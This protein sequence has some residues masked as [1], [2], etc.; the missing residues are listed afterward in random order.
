MP[1]MNLITS[2]SLKEMVT[3]LEVMDVTGDGKDNIVL[4][5]VSGSLRVYDY[6]GGNNVVKELF[7]MT[8]LVPI[9]S[10]GI[11][12]VTGNGTPDFVVGGL[13]NTL[14]VVSIGKKSLEVKSNAMLGNLPIS[15][16]VANVLNDG[17]EE[18]VV[19]TNDNALRC[20]GWYDT[21]L[22]K[23]AH[24]VVKRPVFSMKPLRS[25]GTSYTRFVFGDDSETLYIYQYADDRLHEIANAKVSGEV[26]LVATGRVTGRRSDDVVIASSEKTITLFE[27]EQKSVSTRARI[28][29]PGSISSMKVGEM[30]IDGA[31]SQGQVLV[32]LANSK[33]S[34]LSVEGREFFEDASIKTASKSADSLVA[35]GDLSGDGNKEIVQAVGN[36]LF[37][38]AI[39]SE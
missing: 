15:L 5:T 9:S 13:D 34:M 2:H 35:Y 39:E 25:E 10:F 22:D 33:L 28:R 6:V 30:L 14:R 12:D 11:G 7:R 8:D 20:Y 23:L 21:F 16:V 36:K 1:S 18:V 19:A 3:N 38:V 24:K 26:N 32:S 37:F 17:K 31:R 4:A 27:V 29:A